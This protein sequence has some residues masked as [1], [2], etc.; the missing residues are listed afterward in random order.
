M[1]E[2]AITTG[3]QFCHLLEMIFCY[4]LSET[5]PFFI[6]M[7]ILRNLPQ[8]KNP[9]TLCWG[10]SPNFICFQVP[11]EIF[12]FREWEEKGGDKKESWFHYSCILLRFGNT[13][14]FMSSGDPLPSLRSTHLYGNLPYNFQQRPSLLALTGVPDII[15][16]TCPLV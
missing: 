11:M 10:S 4:L 13:L 8:Q 7:C 1:C 16:P 15:G 9:R 12:L 2:N 5:T 14:R 6:S 3:C